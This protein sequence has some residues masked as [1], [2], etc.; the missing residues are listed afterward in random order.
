MTKNGVVA[1]VGELLTLVGLAEAEP[2]GAQW[3]T[4]PLVENC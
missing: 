1:V 4:T 2:F 3:G